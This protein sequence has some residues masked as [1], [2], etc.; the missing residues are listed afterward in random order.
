MRSEEL[1]VPFN[2]GVNKGVCLNSSKVFVQ[3]NRSAELSVVNCSFFG[4][5]QINTVQ[6]GCSDIKLGQYDINVK[7][8]KFRLI[9]N[10]ADNFVFRS[11]NMRTNE[12]C[13]QFWNLGN[14]IEKESQV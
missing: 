10:R 3:I 2:I 14:N 12:K 6:N 4:I 1:R 5:L 8:N 11:P 9:W 13:A 7:A